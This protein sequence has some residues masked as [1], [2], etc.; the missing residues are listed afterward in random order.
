MEEDRMDDKSMYENR[1]YE[2]ST[3]EKSMEEKSMEEKSMEEKS[4]EEK[5]MEEKSVEEKRTAKKS[6]KRRIS[7]NTSIGGREGRTGGFVDDDERVEWIVEWICKQLPLWGF[8]GKRLESVEVVFKTAIV[9]HLRSMLPAVGCWCVGREVDEEDE[10]RGR[11]RMA[12]KRTLM[13]KKLRDD[14]AIKPRGY[15]F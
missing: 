1:M 8:V 5:R 4:M 11:L 3:G 6:I 9:H 7:G 15:P 2:K 10:M 12:I 14:P 13:K